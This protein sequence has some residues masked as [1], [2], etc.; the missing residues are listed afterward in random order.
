[1]SLRRKNE[2]PTRLTRTCQDNP[3]ATSVRWRRTAIL[4]AS[5][6]VRTSPASEASSF[7]SFGVA[8]LSKGNQNQ[9]P[10]L[11]EL[12]FDDCGVCDIEALE[13]VVSSASADARF[14]L[15]FEDAGCSVGPPVVYAVATED[16]ENRATTPGFGSSR[17]RL[18]RRF[19]S[20][21][22]FAQRRLRA[23]VIH[24]PFCAA[25]LMRRRPREGLL[26]GQWEFPHMVVAEEAR[27]PAKT[28]TKGTP[29]GDASG[30][31]PAEDV[32]HDAETKT[33]DAAASLLHGF[34]EN[35]ADL[36]YLGQKKHIFSHL[37]HE[38][39]VFS[40]DVEKMAE[41]LEFDGEYAWHT[42]EEMQEKGLT[43][44]MRKVLQMYK[45][46]G[47]APSQAKRRSKGEDQGSSQ[48]LAEERHTELGN[49]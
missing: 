13:D 19:V 5:M 28:K 29:A 17:A 24:D 11:Q 2:H 35:A 31:S 7:M 15:A 41:A 45:K 8:A 23:R 27:K 30:A 48:E 32:L 43:T 1:M 21:I 37:R 39:F 49:A 38:M 36:S 14:G 22:L 26:A 3:S 12:T 6:P 4:D 10:G 46:N 20:A 47:K 18:Q 44:G 34:V 16:E 9:M 42:E 33:A 25:F 40:V